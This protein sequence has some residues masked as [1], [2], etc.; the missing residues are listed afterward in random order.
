MSK[1]DV[2]DKPKTEPT[3]ADC[4]RRGDERYKRALA[5]L[6]R[7]APE[8]PAVRAALRRM[9]GSSRGWIHREH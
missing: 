8:S 9:F 6:I 3:G 5:A 1:I 2:Q 4:K 7:R